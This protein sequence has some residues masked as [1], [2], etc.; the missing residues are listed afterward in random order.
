M[1]DQARAER[2]KSIRCE[3]HEDR[4]EVIE[5]WDCTLYGRT[6]HALD[7][8]HELDF[9]D[10]ETRRIRAGDEHDLRIDPRPPAECR[11]EHVK[12]G[13]E[14]LVCSNT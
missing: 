1:P 5:G 8:V 4:G 2:V 12:Y 11:Y 13:P 7:A 3:P 14:R 9:S 6:T 10:L